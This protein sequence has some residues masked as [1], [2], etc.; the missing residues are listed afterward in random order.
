MALRL[1]GYSYDVFDNAIGKEVGCNLL[2][3]LEVFLGWSVL[4]VKF[5]ALTDANG[6]NFVVALAVDAVTN[7][8]TLR[9]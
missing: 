8:F 7:S 3:S 4:V 2:G 6:S 9:V 1:D 5:D